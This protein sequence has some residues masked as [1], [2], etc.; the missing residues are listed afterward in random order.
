MIL[1]QSHRRI[2]DQIPGLKVQGLVHA[3]CV[4]CQETNPL[5]AASTLACTSAVN[6]LQT[7]STFILDRFI[8]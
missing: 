3:S 2:L 8:F 6:S 7:M 5:Y 4:L 1:V